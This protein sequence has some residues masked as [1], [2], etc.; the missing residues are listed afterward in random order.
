MKNV[1]VNNTAATSGGA[2]SILKQ[3]IEYVAK[4]NEENQYYIFCNVDLPEYE[5]LNNVKIVNLKQAKSM[6]IRM[7]WDY[8]GL[9]KW[10]KTN[11]INPDL[12]ISLQNTAVYGFKR[13]P[14]IIY[15]HQGLPFHPEYKW[16]I[17]KHKQLWFYKHI[18]KWLIIFGSKDKTIVVQT[19]W[20]EERVQKVLK[21]V[22]QTKVLRPNGSP[23]SLKEYRKQTFPNKETYTFFYPTS[24]VV[25]KNY[26]VLFDAIKQC[27][28]VE[29]KITLD[30][31]L[32]GD[33]VKGSDHIE[34]LGP[35]S[36]ADTIQQLAEADVLVFPSY[37]ETF[38]LP[39][40]E[41]AEMGKTIIVSD[42]PYSREILADYD[43]V[44]YAKYN[45][46]NSWVNEINSFIKD[47]KK[48]GNDFHFEGEWNEFQTLI[49]SSFVK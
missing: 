19:K 16:S 20:F 12:I 30:S 34:F 14:Q 38:G 36:Y 17:R 39:L 8:F 49:Q 6:K 32:F 44:Y 15:L 5:K 21:K 10:S 29:L 11:D 37:Q 28:N 26:Y 41:A 33:D 27:E 46:V 22:K 40:I 4:T 48:I 31:S 45:D 42:L 47:P 35:L 24:P 9:K 1:F 25:Y 13:V 18:Y 43:R 2:L 23:I 7:Q 3:F